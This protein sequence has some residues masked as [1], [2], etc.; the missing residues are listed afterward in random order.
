MQLEALCRTPDGDWTMVEDLAKVA[1]LRRDARVAVWA[2]ADARDA[3][4]A[5]IQ[6]LAAEFALDELAVADALNPRQRPKLEAYDPHLL[7]VLYQLDEEADQLEPR[8]LACFV[9]PTYVLLLH[10]GADRLVEEIRTRT[11]A[12]GPEMASADRML[13]VVADVAVDDYEAIAG[14]ISDQVEDLETQALTV[15]RAEERTTKEVQ[16]AMPSQYR[17]Y[18]LKQQTSMLRRFALPLSLALERIE[19]REEPVAISDDTEKLFRDV[20]DHVVRVSAQIRSIEDLAQGV[21]DLTQ[22]VQADTLNEINKKLTGW[23]AIVAA[24]ALIAGLYGINYQLVPFT[25]IGA[26]GFVFVLG[27]MAMASLSL[28]LLFKSKGWI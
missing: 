8:Q 18:T 3:S 6:Q 14:R 19:V 21:L 24:P 7:L 9:G 22:S 1:E 17:L 15:A 4:E 28:Y 2:E 11:E 16:G 26:W 27:A 5:D 20:H 23:A 25:R 10:H 13:H 12:G